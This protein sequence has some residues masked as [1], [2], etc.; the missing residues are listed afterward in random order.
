M[1]TYCTTGVL[2]RQLQAGRPE[3]ITHIIVDE[4]HE[5]SVLSDFLLLLLKQLLP[6][7]P[8]LKVILMSATIDQQL[9]SDYFGGIPSLS[10]EGR[11]YPVTEKYLEDVVFDTRYRPSGLAQ[12]IH[13]GEPSAIN[14]SAILT[15]WCE[16]Y[17][18]YGLIPHLLRYLFTQ[19]QPWQG[20]VILVFLSGASEIRS[21]G[22][23][24]EEEFS[25]GQ[26]AVEVIS[27][28]GSLS[29][30]EQKR[31]F[32]RTG[33]S[34]RR[35]VLST[36]IAETSLTI[37]DCTVV[38]DTGREK[39][40]VFNPDSNITEMKEVWVSFASAEQRKGRAGRVQKGTVYRLYTREKCKAFEPF[41]PP[42]MQRSALDALCLQTLRMG[43][44]N[45]QTVLAACISPPAAESVER[46]LRTLQEIQAVR[47]ELPATPGKSTTPAFTLTPLGN[48][49][50]DLPLDCRMAKMLIYGCLLRCVDAV[51]TMAAFLSQ[52]TVFRAPME[53]RDE[54]TA[55]KRSFSHRLSDHLTLLRVYDGWK[56]AKNRRE[57][58]RSNFINYE[59]MLTVSTL[60]K[61][62]IEELITIQFLPRTYREGDGEWNQYGNEENVV[63]GAITAGLYANVVKVEKTKIRFHKVYYY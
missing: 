37:P 51:V 16:R 55:R 15:Q 22:R 23:L 21:V 46:A 45:P 10:V 47:A 50:A 58:C 7:Y 17:Q 61:Q 27:C 32:E 33:A 1:I 12:P 28:H 63:K 31:V 9:F 35:V 14:R 49:V 59:S 8:T 54:M 24:I 34:V 6:D 3:G 25:D 38:I 2:L 42:E 26:F 18:D 5:R 60:R 4:I 20:G 44:G 43:L 19:Q 57:F 29:T 30:Q 39:R 52:R 48:H 62:F 11:L 56:N 36:N 13:E 53:L 40:V 41:T